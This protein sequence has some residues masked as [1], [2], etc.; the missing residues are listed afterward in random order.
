MRLSCIDNHNKLEQFE[1]Q[2]T[3]EWMS[4]FLIV[5]HWRKSEPASVS[6]NK[7]NKYYNCTLVCKPGL[8]FRWMML[9]SKPLG[10]CL[11]VRLVHFY[12]NYPLKI[13]NRA[14]YGSDVIMIVL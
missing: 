2:F 14:L 13:L 12:Q 1:A 11:Q 6:D 3:E 8:K 10:I 7:R 4:L 5:A 9:S